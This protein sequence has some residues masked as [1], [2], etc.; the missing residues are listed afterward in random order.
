M[1]TVET[2]INQAMAAELR[3]E[4]SAT[5]LTI[6]QLSESSG[7]PLSTLK[8][9]LKGRIDVNVAD[10]AA[11][12]RAFVD[13]GKSSADPAELARRAVDRAGGYEVIAR[14]ASDVPSNVSPIKP[15]ADME[16]D[17]IEDIDRQAANV[18]PDA[19]DPEDG[20]D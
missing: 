8:R 15:V 7:I 6:D 18:N 1:G 2:K 19:D 11:L 17:E 4:R 16:P 10:L 9:I 5:E 13:T 3:A 20:T 12:S 14:S